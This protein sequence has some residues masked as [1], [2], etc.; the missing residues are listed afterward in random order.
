MLLPKHGDVTLNSMTQIKEKWDSIRKF[1]W[2]EDVTVFDVF[3]LFI[4]LFIYL[5]LFITNG[6]KGNLDENDF[7]HCYGIFFESALLK[8]T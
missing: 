8:V 3:I 6:K 1:K 7:C 4:Y 2:Y 5:F